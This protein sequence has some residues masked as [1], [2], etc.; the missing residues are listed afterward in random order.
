MK[1]RVTTSVFR[2]ENWLENILTYQTAIK[3]CKKAKKSIERILE[4]QVISGVSQ[5]SALMHAATDWIEARDKKDHMKDWIK[6]MSC[7][8]TTLVLPD[9]T[10]AMPWQRIEILSLSRQL[11]E[12]ESEYQTLKHRKP[13]I[14]DDLQ[15]ST[16]SDK[17]SLK[18]VEQYR[19]VGG[20]LAKVDHEIG[21]LLEK[22]VDMF[23][24]YF[25]K[26][27]WGT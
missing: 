19:E 10:A 1:T 17:D 21:D 6:S 12:K 14:M 3:K 16:L 11:Y 5:E 26:S 8:E 25:D 4:E 23:E 18:L 27:I 7:S 9:L 13:S 2:N 24:L 15:S 20:Q 22:L